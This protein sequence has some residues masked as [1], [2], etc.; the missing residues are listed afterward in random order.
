M[1]WDRIA[2]FLILT[3][4]QVIEKKSQLFTHL[5]DR[6]PNLGPA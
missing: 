6:V 5:C 4:K 1:P 2:G 3:V